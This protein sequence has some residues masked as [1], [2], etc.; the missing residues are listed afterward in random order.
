MNDERLKK[1]RDKIADLNRREEELREKL[2]KEK[3]AYGEKIRDIETKERRQ[4]RKRRDRCM[5]M[6][7]ALAYTHM[8]K[9]RASAFTK[10]LWPLIDEY[11]RKP[12]D[13]ELLNEFLRKGDL[14]ELPPLAEAP[15][16]DDAAKTSAA[17]SDFSKSSG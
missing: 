15:A 7:G 3:A 17:K 11:N 14:P 12:H 4:E 10:T 8:T 6:I 13:R 2:R 16:N 9:N 5:I 1:L